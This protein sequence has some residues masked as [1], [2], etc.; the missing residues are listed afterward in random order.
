[1]ITSL[2]SKFATAALVGSV[3]LGGT[4]AFAAS[5]G[6]PAGGSVRI[7]A[8]PSSGAVSQILI[9]GAIG[10]YGKATSIDK[11]GKTD[12][13]GNYVRIALQKGGFEINSTVLNAK[14]NHAQPK[15]NQ[16]TCSAWFTG[17]GHVTLFKGHGQYAGISGKPTITETYAA[18]LPRF[19]SGTKKGQCNLSNRAQPLS[20]YG[21]ITGVGVVKFS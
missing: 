11:S 21:S 7:F 17:S 15:V 19:K 12:P 1:M 18:V 3:L 4:A 13:N 8:T 6:S 16:A 10:D 5:T 9:T 20:Q 14:F 2:K